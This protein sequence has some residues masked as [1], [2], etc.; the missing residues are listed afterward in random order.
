MTFVPPTVYLDTP[1]KRRNALIH[2][3]S[4][5]IH[6]GKV[7]EPI[8]RDIVTLAENE[9]ATEMSSWLSYSPVYNA[10]F[11][12]SVIHTMPGD[13]IPTIKVNS[14]KHFIAY[15]RVHGKIK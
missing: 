5:G 10:I 2:L 15:L 4:L 7:L 1:E 9:N 11:F 6:W 13:K 14:L 12:S 8:E 3:R